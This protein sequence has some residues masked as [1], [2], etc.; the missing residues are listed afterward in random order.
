MRISLKFDNVHR[1]IPGYHV[2]M[3]EASYVKHH[4]CCCLVHTL[5]LKVTIFVE[6][7]NFL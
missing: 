1:I 3:V 4:K 6:G 5:Y 2:K 7:I